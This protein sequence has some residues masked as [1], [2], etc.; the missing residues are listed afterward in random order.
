MIPMDPWTLFALA[1]GLWIVMSLGSYL[2]IRMYL[3]SGSDLPGWRLNEHAA[4][5]FP[6]HLS[7]Y[8]R[9]GGHGVVLK[10]V[11]LFPLFWTVRQTPAPGKYN[12]LETVRRGPVWTAIPWA[13]RHMGNMSALKVM[14]GNQ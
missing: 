2:Y 6:G 4:S 7:F 11:L 1:T 14:G 12:E 9:S 10:P 8:Q 3:L 5:A 13:V